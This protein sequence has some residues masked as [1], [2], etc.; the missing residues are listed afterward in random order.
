MILY[1]IHG[2]VALTQSEI[3]NLDR[4][5][6]SRLNSRHCSYSEQ[7]QRIRFR[8]LMPF[9]GLADMPF[10]GLTHSTQLLMPFADMQVPLG[11]RKYRGLSLLVPV[12]LLRFFG[13]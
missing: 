6:G 2:T 4:T 12:E 9:D 1:Q 3:S 11:S 13:S 7:M 10:S 8:L 5:A